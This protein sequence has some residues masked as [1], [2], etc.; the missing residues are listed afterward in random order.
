MRF[1]V[2]QHRFYCGIDLH[3]RTMH[4]CILDHAGTVVFDKNLACRPE[5]LLRA[6]EP[7]RE[8]LVIG[9]ECMFAWYWV[10]D[11][12]VEQNIAFMLGH[13]RFS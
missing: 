7:F 2:Q 4:L 5:T 8:D 11:L 9:V 10:A 6:L 12:C 1:Y 13:A 3:A